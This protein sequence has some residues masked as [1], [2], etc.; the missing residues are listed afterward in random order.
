MLKKVFSL[1]VVCSLFFCDFCVFAIENPQSQIDYCK[2]NFGN[3]VDVNC[4][5]NALI[6]NLKETGTNKA[7]LSDIGSNK[8]YSLYLWMYEDILSFA[9]FME[10][11]LANMKINVDLSDLVD[12]TRK[13]LNINQNEAVGVLNRWLDNTDSY[14]NQKELLSDLK[15]NIRKEIYVD[16]IKQVGKKIKQ[17]E[18]VNNDL[19][20]A[21]FN[22]NPLNYSAFVKFQKEGFNYNN[23]TI[24]AVFDK[25][26]K[27][28]DDII[29]KYAIK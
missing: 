24:A 10:Y 9:D 28:L 19:L 1:A 12:G 17:K 21:R 14:V 7:N 8:E 26:S 18:W 25:L 27:K 5:T 15:E 20:L 16:T 3:V 4:A 13:I 6:L 29:K 2:D 22:F 23:K 11:S